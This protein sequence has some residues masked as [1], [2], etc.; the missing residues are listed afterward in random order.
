MVRASGVVIGL[1]VLAVGLAALPKEAVEV[2][3]QTGRAVRIP[4]PVERL[5]SA[6]GVATYYVYALGA[7]D[8]LVAANYVGLHGVSEAPETLRRMDPGLGE[9]FS[10]GTPNLEEIVALAPDLVL[11]NPVKHGD[12]AELLG[13]LGIPAL[14]IVAE[15]QGDLREAM[16]SIGRALGPDTAVRAEAFCAYLDAVLAEI[17]AALADVPERERPRVLFVGSEPL[18]VAS[19]DM[20]QTEM[21]EIA[22][23]IS[24]TK[25]LRGHWKD[26]SI[27]QVLVWDP[28][29]IVI[30]PYG[31][32]Q[33]KDILGDPYWQALDA[34]REGRVCKMP[35]LAAPWDTPV[36]ES[37]LGIIWL[38]ER[39]H[40]GRVR[41]GLEEE[42]RR[43]Y[44][45]FY[46]YE[47]SERDALL[48]R[49]PAPSGEEG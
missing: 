42:A 11:T 37:V 46:G 9:R 40:P 38:A 15:T 49:E 30:A 29:V 22:G 10:F 1:L 31:K 24:T 6:Y 34:V 8:S 44:R 18:C 3:D 36:P 4:G 26:V 27:E 5:V 17:K 45:E 7:A 2:V 16:L 48:L 25:G 33:P 13:D 28:E 39:L 21:I 43:F 19:G 41:L 23:G 12:L 20:Y 32:V 14:Q 47:L 35:R